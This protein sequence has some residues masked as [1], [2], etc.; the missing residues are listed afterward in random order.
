MWL[1]TLLANRSFLQ[2]IVSDATSLSTRSIKQ[3]DCDAL[4][5]YIITARFVLHILHPDHDHACCHV[6]QSV[7]N[8]TFSSGTTP[9]PAFLTKSLRHE[10]CTILAG[11][12]MSSFTAR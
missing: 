5:N 9:S 8:D 11:A 12:R 2:A 7:R 3:D 1:L 4:R 10:V 6:I